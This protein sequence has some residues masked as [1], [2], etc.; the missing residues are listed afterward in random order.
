LRLALYAP[1][2]SQTILILANSYLNI[3]FNIALKSLSWSSRR[4]FFRVKI[5][6]FQFTGFTS[7]SHSTVCH[8]LRNTALLRSNPWSPRQG[9]TNTQNCGDL[10]IKGTCQALYV[11]NT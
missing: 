3:H 7:P 9:V 10:D 8:K 2:L 6:A 11:I 5:K 4:P 1:L